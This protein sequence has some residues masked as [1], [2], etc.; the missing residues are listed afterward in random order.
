MDITD[1][2]SGLKVQID[3]SGKCKLR[4][5][6]SSNNCYCAC[7]FIDKDESLSGVVCCAL[8]EFSIHSL[9]NVKK[10]EQFRNLCASTSLNWEKCAA[11]GKIL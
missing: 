4:R 5:A 6:L 11:I 7:L 1:S 9:P 2:R 3:G 10:H 8:Y